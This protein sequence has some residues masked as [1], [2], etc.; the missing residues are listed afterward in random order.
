MSSLGDIGG[1]VHPV[2][3]GNRALSAPGFRCFLGNGPIQAPTGPSRPPRIGPRWS[4]L[5]RQR[6]R[7]TLNYLSAHACPPTS[8]SPTL[9]AASC[10]RPPKPAG[11][12]RALTS[13][14]IHAPSGAAGR[15][16]RRSHVSC[17]IPR[18]GGSAQRYP[19]PWGWGD[20]DT[21]HCVQCLVSLC[22]CVVRLKLAI[23]MG[24]SVRR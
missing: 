6:L 20:K 10:S 24:L 5:Y 16:P 11:C 3:N 4:G 14:L 18:A 1:A 7:L 9:G 15:A 2:E 12:S 8:T 23:K 17:P 22:P 21:R 13:Y 19:L